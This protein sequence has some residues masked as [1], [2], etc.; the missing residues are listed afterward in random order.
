MQALSS[1]PHRQLRSSQVASGL[2]ERS[3]KE[4]R[5]MSAHSD[6]RQA[7][8]LSDR[9]WN[10]RLGSPKRTQVELLNSYSDR[11]SRN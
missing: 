4:S 9:Q 8:L 1:R 11:K 2:I 10:K 7:A 3:S 5:T 6:A